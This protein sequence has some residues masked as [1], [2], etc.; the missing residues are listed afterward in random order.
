LIRVGSLRLRLSGISFAIKT[1]RVPHR[2]LA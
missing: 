2:T 1:Y